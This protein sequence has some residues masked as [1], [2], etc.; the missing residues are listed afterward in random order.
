MTRVRWITLTAL[1]GALA[2]PPAQAAA[3]GEVE[4]ARAERSYSLAPIPAGTDI[5]VTLDQ[6]VRINQKNLNE[7]FDAQVTRDVIVDGDVAIRQGAP[8]QVRLVRSEE[9]AEQAT[10]RLAEVEI[11]GEMRSVTTENARADTEKDRA[12]T[13]KKTGIGAAAGAVIG[14]VTGAGV[15]KGAVIGAG[16]GLAWGLLSSRDREVGRGTLLEFELSKTVN[17][18]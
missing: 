13:A 7:T 1:A 16:G 9:N 2:F 5:P 4:V 6:D 12:G 10:L 14:A 8:A 17:A 15:L 11:D 18:R 3:Q